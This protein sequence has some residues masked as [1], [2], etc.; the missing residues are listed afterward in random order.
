MNGVC[1]L[2]ANPAT[3]DTELSLEVKMAKSGK[4]P[5]EDASL[6]IRYVDSVT[7]LNRRHRC[8]TA[9]PKRRRGDSNE[10]FGGTVRVER[11]NN[12]WS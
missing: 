7:N 8:A 10:G 11:K 9:S 6:G 1:D 3:R 4:K 2:V 12:R 5:I